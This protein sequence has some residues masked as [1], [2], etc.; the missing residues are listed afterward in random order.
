MNFRLT[1]AA[2]LSSVL[3]VLPAIGHAAER[4]N[5]LCAADNDWCELMRNAFEKETQIEVSMVRK[6]AGEIFAQIRAEASNPK[7]DLWWA[8]TGDPHLQAAADGYTEVYKSPQLDKLQPWAQKQAEISGYRT[9]G[10]YAGLLGI[11]YNPEVLKRK[12]VPAPKCWKDLV[13]PSYKGEIQIAN[14]NSSGTA[15]ATL[16]TLVQLQGENEAF[17]FLKKMNDNVNQYTKSGSAPGKA[18][19]RGEIGVGLTFQ[20]DL[21][22]EAVAGFP[23]EVVSPCEG[24]GYEIGSMSIVKGAKNMASAKRFYEFALRPDVQSLAVKAGAFQ[25][26]SNKAATI[27]ARAPRLEQVKTINYDFAKYGSDETRK[28]LLKRWDDEIFSISR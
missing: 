27:P 24:T 15:Y 8:G 17:S 16:A 28:R 13:A 21:L 7:T 26:P 14:P 20:H 11:G 19:A 6:S 22:K 2:L 18:L 4:I 25:V 1:T 9:V 23:V 5:V 12:N 10:V 3:C